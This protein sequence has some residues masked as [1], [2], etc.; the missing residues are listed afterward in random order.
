[1]SDISIPGISSK[2]NTNKLVDDLVKAERI[3][4][5]KM[6]K[7]VE[8][9]ET[10]RSIWRQINRELSTLQTAVKGLYGFENPFEDKTVRSSDERTVTASAERIA[11]IDD[12]SIIAKRIATSDKFLTPDLPTDFRVGSGDYTFTVGKKSVTLK[13]NGGPLEDFVGRL[14]VKAQGIIQASTVR[15]TNRTQVLMIQT[16]MTGVQNK[17]IF[18]DDALKFARET[19]ILIPKSSGSD[20]F[21]IDLATLVKNYQSGNDPGNAGKVE[22]GDQ[23]IIIQPSGQLS[24]PFDR[25]IRMREGLVLEYSYRTIEVEQPSHGPLDSP[26]T[27]WIQVPHAD[28]QGINIQSASEPVELPL[29]EEILSSKQFDTLN[30]FKVATSMGTVNLPSITPDDEYHTVKISAKDL[31][32]NIENFLIDNTSTSRAIV[33]E[34]IRIDEPGAGGGL[35]PALA[36]ETAGDAIIEFRGIEVRRSSNTIDDLVDGLTINL[37]QASHEP[38]SLSVEPDVEEA[39]EGIIRFVFSYNKL[40]SRILVLTSDEQKVV[41][42]MAYIEDEQRTEYEEQLG[43]FRGQ[44]SLTRLRSQLQRIIGNPHPTRSDLTLL[45]QIGISTNASSGRINNG[46][47]NLSKLRGY[48]EINEKK[49]DESLSSTMEAVTEL[50]GMDTNGDLVIDS[51]VAKSMDDLITPYTRTGGLSD[52]RVTRLDDQIEDAKE[53]IQDYEKHLVDYE[54]KLKREYGNMEGMLNRLENSSKELNNFNSQL[55]GSQR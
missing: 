10:D 54:A 15:N 20:A 53:D 32:G 39:K 28:Y 25:N 52:L 8:E 34:D 31:S 30:V 50:F 26:D 19:G 44:Y 9:L 14:N 45:T 4:L 16:G 48:L 21:K 33:I 46:S 37:K 47:L 23:G 36:A 5:S 6:E 29:P 11:K 41:D 12:Y 42:E 7:D 55:G 22:I 13:Y 3:P 24:I 35:Q 38:V 17:L 43:R 1:M 2:Y 27:R 49:L 51:G 18:E 40:V